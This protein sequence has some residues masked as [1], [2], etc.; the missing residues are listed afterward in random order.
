MA[1]FSSFVA[2]SWELEVP[3][4]TLCC[5][6]GSA[7]FPLSDCLESPKG[8][9]SKEAAIEGVWQQLL[10]AEGLLRPARIREDKLDISAKLPQKLPAGAARSR[11]GGPWPVH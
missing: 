4:S 8:L 10:E 3:D 1:A 7:A 6:K 2:R 5:H 11:S 9:F